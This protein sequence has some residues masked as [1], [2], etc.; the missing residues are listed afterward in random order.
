MEQF[1]RNTYKKQSIFEEFY[2]SCL[3]KAII[4]AIL[5]LLLGI[6]AIMSVPNESIMMVETEDNVRQCLQDNDSI[7]GDVIDEIVW[8]IGRTFSQA[9]TTFDNK[10]VLE[11]CWKYNKIETYSHTFYS[12]A[13]IRNNT[14]TEGVRVGF[15]IFGI[16]ISTVYYS[17]LV[18]NLG[19]VRGKYNQRLIQDVVVPDE[20][21]G[22]NP[23]IKPYHYQ[24]NPDN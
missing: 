6:V 17:D 8:N 13:R 1:N 21:I 19:P 11:A 23:N 5:A 12:T 9:D 10:E 24:G 3:G 22:D 7:K 20:Y 16:V 14:H 18:M 15:G 4:L 2:H